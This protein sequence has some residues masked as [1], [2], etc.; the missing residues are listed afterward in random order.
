MNDATQWTPPPP[1][2]TSASM[3]VFGESGDAKS[4]QCALAAL[5]VAQKYRLRTR[6]YSYDEGGIPDLVEYLW[7]EAKVIDVFRARSID[8]NGQSLMSQGA[9]SLY[10]K[11]YWP[12]ALHEDGTI[13]GVDLLPPST[14]TFEFLCP[15]GH[16]MGASAERGGLTPGPCPTCKTAVHGANAKVR[17][18]TQKAPHFSD[19]GLIVHDGITAACDWLTGERGELSARGL[20]GGESGRGGGRT[21]VTSMG[22]RFGSAGMSAI[23]EIQEMPRQ[24]SID[25]SQV[26][27]IVAPTIWT[28]RTLRLEVSAKNINPVV[29][30]KLV[31]KA[32]TGEATAWYGNSVN[33]VKYKG[34]HRIYYS[35]W[36]EED[37]T[38]HRCKVRSLPASLPEDGYLVRT[39]EE[40]EAFAETGDELLR[41]GSCSLGKL[42]DLMLEA[43]NEGVRKFVDSF[44]LAL[45]PRAD[46]RP[47]DGTE[48]FAQEPAQGRPQ[49]APASGAPRPVPVARPV[50]TARPAASA[51]AAPP[52]KAEV[53]TPFDD[54]APPATGSIPT[55]PAPSPSVRPALPVPRPPMRQAPVAPA[56][57]KAGA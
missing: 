6:Y 39:P 35:Q 43:R 15:S 45:P 51:A 25:S 57:K 50:P 53:A 8:P 14:T 1:L 3:L 42:F 20:A 27:G 54:P 30:P 11:G 49:A 12:A 36:E 2:N 21:V 48:P 5:W 16:V 22:I 56:P 7:K 44:G 17:R 31:G 47:D 46:A 13:I 52:A 9:M 41:F 55:A 10:A 26:F 28:A 23:G 33:V 18:V 34:E 38:V 32:K 19:I 37:G 29:G 24:W 40:A 4:T